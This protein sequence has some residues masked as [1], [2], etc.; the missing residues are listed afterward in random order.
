MAKEI[1]IY[2]LERYVDLQD[3]REKNKDQ[4]DF[5]VKNGFNAGKDARERY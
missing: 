2:T 1:E 4:K 3:Q 5:V